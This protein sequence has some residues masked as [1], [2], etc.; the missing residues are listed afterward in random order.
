MP[1]LAELHPI[2]VHFVIALAMVGV[3]LRVASLVAP[4]TW[5]RHAATALLLIAAVTSLP[6]VKS[7]EEAHGPAERI[8]G[9][10]AIVQAHEEAGENARNVLL[11]VGAIELAALALRARPKAV[12]VL[13]VAA[14]VCGLGAASLVYEAA[15]EG[16][17]LV[18]SYAGGVGTR[19]GDTV[20]VQRLLIAGLFHQARSA[21][22][23]GRHD[24]AARLTAELGR[25]RPDDPV[26]QLLGAES[27]LEDARDARGALA[28]L[29]AIPVAGDAPPFIGVRHG[30]LVAKA[31]ARLGFADSAR[32]TLVALRAR[33]PQARSIQP[34]LDSVDQFTPVA[35]PAATAPASGAPK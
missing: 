9:A 29:R 10:R 23:A 3:V 21:R 2:L 8:P 34:V 33:Y 7:G 19:T 24:E 4:W 6:A 16:G 22:A 20:D 31:E 18:Y 11:I 25:Q 17:A 30:I 28:V 15:E 12:R 35:A 32:A 5:V 13:H 1:P 14:A 27:R 26:V